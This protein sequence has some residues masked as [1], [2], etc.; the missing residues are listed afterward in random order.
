M[1]NTA[2]PASIDSPTNPGT[3]STLATV[4][5]H[6]QHGLENDAIVALE[7]KLGTGSSLQ[8]PVQGGFLVSN[9]N[10]ASQW[11]VAPTS[12]QFTTGI[13]DPNGKVWI[14]QTPAGASAV[15]YV[16]ISNSIT[17]VAPSISAL[18]SDNNISLNLV[19][20]GSGKVQDNGTNLIDFRSSFQNF[21]FTG[22]IWSVG[23]GLQASMSAATIFIGGI[24][25]TVAAVVNHTFGA[26]VDTYVDYTVGTGI[27]YT[28]VA[29]AAVPPALAANSM[30]LACVSSGGA[31][32]TFI[33]NQGNGVSQTASWYQEIAR[34]TVASGTPTTIQAGPFPAY[35]YLRILVVAL[36]STTFSSG[37]M[38]FNGDTGASNYPFRLSTNGGADTTGTTN[39]LAMDAGNSTQASPTFITIDMFNVAAQE[40]VA[41]IQSGDA[42]T[43]GTGGVPNRRPILAKWVNTSAQATSLAFVSAAG[44]NAGSEIIVMGHN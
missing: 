16:N 28:A 5:H 1:S 15:N 24:E 19:P 38:Q 13:N 12:P 34:S 9:S 7:T 44:L 43:A 39:G 14:G 33:T 26:S 35:K 40:K 2:Y 10:G 23:A 36:V 29:N 17:A 21:L 6:L 18:G 4:P 30:R 25:Y 27:T 11:Q 32:I 41:V 37:R 8:T 42:G 31:S 20:K 3:G 22:G